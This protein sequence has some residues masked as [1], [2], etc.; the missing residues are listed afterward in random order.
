MTRL[1]AHTVEVLHTPARMRRLATIIGLSLIIINLSALGP[2]FELAPAIWLTSALLAPIAVQAA[3]MPP[4]ALVPP[5][6]FEANIVYRPLPERW[7]RA[8][9]FVI[10]ACWALA[11]PLALLA[12]DKGVFVTIGLVL[13]SL[14]VSL[15]I[16]DRVRLEGVSF[17]VGEGGVYCASTMRRTVPWHAIRGVRAVGR[18]STAALI[19]DCARPA[20]YAS[21][22]GARLPGAEVRLSLAD[23]SEEEQRAIC[24]RILRRLA[25]R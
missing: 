15:E 18:G 4:R 11:S 25:A 16:L 23:L 9:S 13:V 20:D 3:V 10:P 2:A 21:G 17:S 12:G 1:N 22:L 24:E 7:V 6:V 5:V 8:W 19:I 14:F